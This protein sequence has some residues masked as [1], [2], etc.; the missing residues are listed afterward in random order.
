MNAS[1]RLRGFNAGICCLHSSVRR[2]DMSIGG[3]HPSGRIC[4]IDPRVCGLHPRIR[5]RLLRTFG[6]AAESSK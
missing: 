3:I 1:I 6:S 4:G 5:R 2:S